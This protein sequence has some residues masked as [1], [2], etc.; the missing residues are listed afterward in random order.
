MDNPD[1]LVQGARELVNIDFVACVFLG[2]SDFTRDGLIESHVFTGNP[3]D[4]VLG[5]R[6]EC[7]GMVGTV[8]PLRVKSNSFEISTTRSM[9]LA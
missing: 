7:R 5:R 9:L 3:L 6:L 2:F 4:V 8:P 1:P